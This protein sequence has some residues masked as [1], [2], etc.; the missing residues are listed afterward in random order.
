MILMYRLTSTD[1]NLDHER[2]FPA[3][4]TSKHTSTQQLPF[5]VSTPASPS[6]QLNLDPPILIPIPPVPVP[7][8]SLIDNPNLNAN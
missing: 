7:T 3:T 8:V 2:M 6:K 1:H 4:P 5:P